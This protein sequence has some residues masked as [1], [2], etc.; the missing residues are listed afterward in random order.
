MVGDKFTF[1]WENYNSDVPNTLRQLWNDNDFC[2]V[3]LATNDD[4]NIRAHKVILSSSS[5]MFRDILLKNPHTNPLIY[6]NSLKS[7]VVKL[8]IKFIYLGQ[9]EVG[10]DGLIDFLAA[11]K[12]LKI[13][14]LA[15]E[16]ANI[17][18]DYHIAPKEEKVPI[19]ED[20]FTDYST[21]DKIYK[22]NSISY[23]PLHELEEE[24][25]SIS[26]KRAPNEIVKPC[27][28]VSGSTAD[29]KTE[30]DTC[31]K[32]GENKFTWKNMKSSLSTYNREMAEYAQ[33][34]GETFVS[35][36]E[37]SADHLLEHLPIFLNIGRKT[38]GELFSSNSLTNLYNGLRRYLGGR[39]EQIDL[40][41]DPRFKN[42]RTI[43]KTKCLSSIELGRGPGMRPLLQKTVFCDQCDHKS[44]SKRGMRHHKQ[45]KHELQTDKFD[46]FK[47]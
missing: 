5:P 39:K 16:K 37:A 19:S 6:F 7:D 36:E 4:A 2:D 41:H 31:L 1:S 10:Q 15:E 38:N 33:Q 13:K 20:K 3:T 30:D 47:V 21:E 25:D 45:Y 34:N 46:S 44:S 43:L 22:S 17:H 9:C 8:I 12:E 27:I 18:Q 40:K 29:D 28:M 42:V 24:E 14:G 32:E 35:L 11:G 26:S 23:Q